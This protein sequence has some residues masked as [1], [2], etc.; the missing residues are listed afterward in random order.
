MATN[1]TELIAEVRAFTG[2]TDTSTFSDSDISDIIG[3]AKE[4]IRGELDA[5]DFTFFVDTSETNTHSADRALFWLSCI[6]V[7]VRAG[8]IATSDFTISELET[9]RSEGQFDL[10][11]DRFMKQLR[12]AQ[13]TEV[14]GASANSVSR[15]DRS[16][17]YEVYDPSYRNQP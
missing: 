11:F 14:Q 5:P 3:V 9:S 12:S 16:Y 15:T 2:Y 1:E 17:D 8:E 7:K 4:E 6:G 10:L 13:S